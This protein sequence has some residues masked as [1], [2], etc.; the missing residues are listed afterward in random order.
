MKAGRISPLQQAVHVR[1]TMVKAVA[2]QAGERVDARKSA[3]L[4]QPRFRRHVLKD[5]LDE[6]NKQYPK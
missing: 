6:F 2:T 1:S 3:D 5:W 4:G